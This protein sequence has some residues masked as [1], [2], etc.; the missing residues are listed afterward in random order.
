[1]C[2]RSAIPASSRLY[3]HFLGF[4]LTTWT[5]EI[6]VCEYIYIHTHT[7]THT[8]IY[9]Y[10]YIYIYIY[11][12]THTYTLIAFTVFNKN[13]KNKHIYKCVKLIVCCF[14]ML[15][16]DYCQIVLCDFALVYI[17]IYIYICIYIHLH[18]YVYVCIHIYLIKIKRIYKFFST[19]SL[20]PV[21]KDC[22]NYF[23]VNCN[24]NSFVA[25]TPAKFDHSFDFS[26]CFISGRRDG[27][28]NEERPSI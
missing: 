27:S 8:Y 28:A 22:K 5:N 3:A 7:H 19:V 4:R 26:I 2:N 24:K 6:V 11:I 1:V 20:W 12:Y 21:K 16:Y 9:T 17:Y 18:T 23:N 15:P 25:V 13:T 14:F 10:I